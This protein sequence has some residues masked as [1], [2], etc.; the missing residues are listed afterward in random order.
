MYLRFFGFEGGNVN[1]LTR[2]VEPTI[3]RDVKLDSMVMKEEIFGPILPVIPY[4]RTEVTNPITIINHDSLTT[5]NISYY[6]STL[7]NPTPFSIPT[8][9][10][11]Q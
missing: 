10:L 1:V 4:R 3:L 8:P 5:T 2:Y 7:T 11:T 9:L 6:Q